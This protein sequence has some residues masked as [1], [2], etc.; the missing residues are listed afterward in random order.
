MTAPVA[1]ANDR[2][3]LFPH[4]GWPG[5]STGA[6]HGRRRRR[7]RRRHP[8]GPPMGYRNSSRRCRFRFCLRLV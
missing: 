2:R 8:W 1:G 5:G 3:D 4:L 6:A 7:S